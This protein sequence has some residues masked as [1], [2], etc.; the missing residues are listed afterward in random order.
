MHPHQKRCLYLRPCQS[1]SFKKPRP[2]FE[3]MSKSPDEENLSYASSRDTGAGSDSRV[4]A[5]RPSDALAIDW[6]TASSASIINGSAMNPRVPLG[7]VQQLK[8]RQ[9]DETNV[10]PSELPLVFLPSRSAGLK[11]TFFKTRLFGQSHWINATQKVPL[12]L[13]SQLLCFI[14]HSKV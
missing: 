2:D 10:R 8:Q 3:H 9:S 6:M 13:L 12:H 7:N 11:G 5:P 14:C 4:I 1:T